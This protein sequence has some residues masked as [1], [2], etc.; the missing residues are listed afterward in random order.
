MLRDA[1]QRRDADGDGRRG[2]DDVEHVVRAATHAGSFIVTVLEPRSGAS[3]PAR[4]LEVEAD[5]VVRRDPDD[6]LGLELLA[7]TNHL[8][9]K[10]QP[11]PEGRWR[12]I[13]RTTRTRR[14]R[15]DRDALWDLGRRLRLPSVVH[16]MLVGADERVLGVWLRRPGEAAQTDTAPVLLT[17]DELVSSPR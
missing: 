8:R 3:A 16:T 1:V 13:E 15:F 5:G 9:A 6:G 12:T 7:A 10:A 14:G 11:R 2:A 17:W 4:V